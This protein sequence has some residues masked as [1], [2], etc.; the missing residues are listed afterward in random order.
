MINYN[1]TCPDCG[2]HV[3]EEVMNDVTQTSSIDHIEL[4][5]DG[6]IA[7]DY[8]DVSCDGG[9]PD[10]IYY[11]CQECGYE[12]SIDEMVTI[13]EQNKEDE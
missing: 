8:G 5:E 3:I 1:W 2:C 9:N 11:Q 6:T 10:T 4:L 13:A 7:V 12:V